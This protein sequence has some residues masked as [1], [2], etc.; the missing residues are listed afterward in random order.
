MDAD[1]LKK[2]AEIAL[3]VGVN[4]QPGQVLVIGYGNR[5]VW[6]EQFE[7][8]R[9]ATE[10]AYEMGARFVQVDWGDEAWM[11]STVAHADL[12]LLEARYRWQVQWVEQL[13]KEGAAYL[14]LPASNPDLYQGID[15][16]RVARAERMQ[17]SI[18]QSFTQHRT[19]DEY[20]WSLLSVPTQAWADKVFPQL[21]KEERVE[22]LWEAIFACTRANLEDP[23]GAWQDHLARLGKR[24]EWMTNLGIRAL[25]YTAPGTDLH[26]EFHPDHYWHVAST[27]TPEGVRFV[28]N[29]PTEEVYASPLKTG[30]NGTVRST[31][32]LNH[33]G[34]LIDG[35]ELTFE[36]GRIVKYRADQGEDALRSIVETDEGSHYL[37]EIALVPV[38]SPIA[39]QGILFYNTLFDENASC[40]LAIG[41]AYPLVKGGRTL[42]R[43][44]WESKGL[45]DSMVHVDFM[46]GS[47]EL[48]VDA[49]TTDG[50]TVPI[51]R[52]GLWVGEY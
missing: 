12:D 4:L 8:A 7:F 19:S 20:S 52:K 38:D 1:S 29:M 48:D 37:G 2:Y 18:Y 14:A 23:F 43:A 13:A 35:I 31:L 45:N 9:V 33:G 27:E 32:P 49:E 24:A 26:V 22:A 51:L 40:H 46:I 3:R 44:E 50:R 30:V 5:Q 39:Q 34:S 25:H 15:G 36:N 41:M 42:P 16:S 6:P 17:R 47:A 11:R 28:P 21:P 10:A